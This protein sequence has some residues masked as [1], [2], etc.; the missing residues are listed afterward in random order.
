MILAEWLIERGIGET[1]AA[2]VEDGA[3]LE[4][5]IEIEGELICGAIVEAKLVEQ[6]A[7]KRAGL[8]RFGDGGE[9]LVEP[10]PE[11]LTEGATGLFEIVRAAIP[12]PG[13]PKLAKARHAPRAAAARPAR[14]LAERLGADHTVVE[15]AAHGPDRLEH[16]GWSELIEQAQSGAVAFPGGALRIALTPAMTVIDVDGALPP[17]PLAIAGAKAAAQA[18]RRLD[19]QGS[20]GIDLPTLEARADRQAAAE[21]F[22]AH[23]PQPFERTAVNGFG[24]LQIVRKRSGPSLAEQFQYDRVASH[25]RALLRRAERTPGIGARTIRAHPTIA[26]AL[27]ANPVWLADLERRIGAPVRIETDALLATGGGTVSAETP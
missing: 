6:L 25:A 19:I 5:R 26:A 9:A 14:P 3:I 27:A 18:I 16:T 21:A 1:R 13:R 11:G 4:A 2:L 24:F 20:I 22:D 7:G 15:V 23:L 12:E 17:A 10:L 8:L